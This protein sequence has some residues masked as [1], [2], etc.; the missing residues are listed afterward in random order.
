MMCGQANRLLKSVR[1]VAGA[2]VLGVAR[3][4]QE[5]WERLLEISGD[6]DGLEETYEEWLRN[7][8]RMLREMRKAGMVAKRVDVDVDELLLWCQ[9][10][11]RPVDIGSR[12]QYV[13]KK[14]AQR[15][16][17]GDE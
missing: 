10:H 12:A 8:E 3:Y 15:H 14:L 9:E 6:R 5:Q 11:S 16:E 7:A 13:A 1:R 2:T 4:R 17:Q